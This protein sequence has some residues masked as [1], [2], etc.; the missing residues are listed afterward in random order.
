MDRQGI[1]L[2]NGDHELCLSHSEGHQVILYSD[3]ARSK[4]CVQVYAARI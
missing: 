1:K 2:D 4:V 3:P